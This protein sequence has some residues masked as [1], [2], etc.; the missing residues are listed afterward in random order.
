MDTVKMMVAVG[1]GDPVEYEV[2]EA[3][4]DLFLS[5]AEIGLEGASDGANDAHVEDADDLRQALR[6]Q[7][8]TEQELQNDAYAKYEETGDERLR[9]V[10]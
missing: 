2:S 4:W 8:K 5:A 6:D 3:A 7:L 10:I 9:T 1:D